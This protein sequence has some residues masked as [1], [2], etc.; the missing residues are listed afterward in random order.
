MYAHSLNVCAE[1]L[2]DEMSSPSNNDFLMGVLINEG[3]S[4][5][6]GSCY[7]MA[8]DSDLITCWGNLLLW[9]KR[10]FGKGRRGVFR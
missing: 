10:Q 1:D 4:E 9:R 5:N 6:M 3:V 2:L 7:E 8:Q